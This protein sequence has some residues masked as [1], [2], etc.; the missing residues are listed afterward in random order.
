VGGGSLLAALTAGWVIYAF[1]YAAEL[2]HIAFGAAPKLQLTY[3]LNNFSKIPSLFWNT[4]TQT[5]QPLAQMFVGNLGWQDTL[6]PSIY[7]KLV[8]ITFLMTLVAEIT[9][10][11][12]WNTRVTGIVSLA[13][14][15]AVGCLYISLY[16]IWTSVGKDT[17]DGVAGRYLLPLAMFAG[18]AIPRLVRL[19]WCCVSA[20]YCVAL[21]PLLTMYYAPQVIIERYYLR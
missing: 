6:F 1:S 19:D 12:A 4:A 13:V 18:I 5:Y 15:T 8:G 17:I 3:L 2:G 20:A 21:S 16:L 14:V 7:Y 10:R 9:D 11:E